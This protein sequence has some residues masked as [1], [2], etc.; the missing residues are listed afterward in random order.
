MDSLYFVPRKSMPHF[1]AAITIEGT[2]AA[3]AFIPGFAN[4]IDVCVDNEVAT[5]AHTREMG[6]LV[7]CAA[8]RIVKALDGEITDHA[9]DA[10]TPLG[11]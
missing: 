10:P 6:V 3:R 1:N 8:Y 11:Q 7:V 4:Q 5:R 2:M 9:H